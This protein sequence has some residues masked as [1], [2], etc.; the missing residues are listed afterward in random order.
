MDA[1]AGMSAWVKKERDDRQ[2][3]EDREA[4]RRER[5]REAKLRAEAAAAA[6]H[7]GR[8]SYGQPGGPAY[9]QYPGTLPSDPVPATSSTPPEEIAATAE[10]PVEAISSLPVQDSLEPGHTAS[11]IAQS[12]GTT[13][14]ALPSPSPSLAAALTSNILDKSLV[15]GSARTE[16]V[17]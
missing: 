9:P 7:Y 1:A 5:M 4:E 12:N 6:A 13:D 16:R 11:N 3:K 10:N 8:F 14:G 2:A 15:N 17:R